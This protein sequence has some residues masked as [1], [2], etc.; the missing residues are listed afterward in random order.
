MCNDFSDDVF[1]INY[2]LNEFLKV[3]LKN[4]S[5]SINNYKKWMLILL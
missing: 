3:I 1:S 5:V 4:V 2:L